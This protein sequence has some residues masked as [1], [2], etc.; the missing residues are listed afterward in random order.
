MQARS[1]L[2]TQWESALI[3]YYLGDLSSQIVITN[4]FR[5][6][7]YE[8]IRGLRAMAIG[9]LAAIPSYKWFKF[10]GDNFNLRR[11]GVWG[12]IAA[13]IAVHQA[14]FVPVFN[15]YFFGAQTIFAG[16]T[17]QEAKARVLRQVPVS[18]WKSC[19]FWPVVNAFVFSVVPWQYRNVFSG[20]V[21]IGW[22]TYLCWLNREDERRVEAVK[23]EE[24]KTGD[25]KMDAGRRAAKKV[26]EDR[27]Q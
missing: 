4:S 15:A 3:I 8:P 12:S 11:G 20:V 7:R 16:G 27:G 10:L 9:A 1:P 21:A 2:I 25:K 5:E 13:R 19:Q 23:K 22:Q 26:G 6:E 24:G 14:V 17:L 18:W